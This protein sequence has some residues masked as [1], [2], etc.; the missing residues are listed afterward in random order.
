M[1]RAVYGDLWDWAGE[2]RTVDTGTTNTGLAGGA[3]YGSATSGISGWQAQGRPP[4]TMRN[5]KDGEHMM[6]EL[7]ELFFV[8][9]STVYQ[10]I[11]RSQRPP[12]PSRSV[13]RVCS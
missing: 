2:I 6:G 10:A 12:E 13:D 4:G 3:S 5:N 7:A 11:E 1:R 9:C 8:G